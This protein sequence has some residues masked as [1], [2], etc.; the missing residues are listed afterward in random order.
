MRC[1]RGRILAPHLVHQ[2]LVWDHVACSKKERC[3]DGPL[4]TATQ[5]DG[6]FVDFGL[7]PAENAEPNLLGVGRPGS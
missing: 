6:A 4:L 5:F 2:A 7:E 3:E 1:R